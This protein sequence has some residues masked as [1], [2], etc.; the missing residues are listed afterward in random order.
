MKNADAQSIK[1][2]EQHGLELLRV[3]GSG[4]EAAAQEEGPGEAGIRRQPARDRGAERGRGA[5]QHLAQQT[6]GFRLLNYF[7]VYDSGFEASPHE[8]HGKLAF[9]RPDLFSCVLMKQYL[10][11]FLQYLP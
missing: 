2:R 9:L 10:F 4:L 8:R 3:E 11:Y 7:R 1:A 6:L 5:L